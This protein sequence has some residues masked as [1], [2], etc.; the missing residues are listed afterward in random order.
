MAGLNLNRGT[1]QAEPDIVEK[2]SMRGLV[3]QLNGTRR[4]V[5]GE[6]GIEPGQITVRLPQSTTQRLFRMLH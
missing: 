4:P 3:K 2:I 1:I 5:S 6:D